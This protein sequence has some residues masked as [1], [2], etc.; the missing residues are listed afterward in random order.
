VTPD[1]LLALTPALYVFIGVLGALIGSFLNVV[2]W[3]VPRGLSIVHPGSACPSCGHQITSAEN[4]PI[5]SW[6]ALHGRCS[7]CRGRISARYPMVEAAT[8]ALFILMAWTVGFTPI[9]PLWLYM[10]AAGTALF[11]IDVD[12]KRLPDVIV[13][14]S[15]GVI[16]AG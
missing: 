11:L 6:L 3:R 1:D 10:A 9:L 7:S 4:I 12:H 16:L 2:I 14:P 13:L 5:V 15:W 8:A